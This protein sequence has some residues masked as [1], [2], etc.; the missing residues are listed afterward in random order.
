MLITAQSYNK[1]ETSIQ[2]QREESA[3][4]SNESRKM[5]WI[6][7]VMRERERESLLAQALNNFMQK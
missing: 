3:E 4:K 5:L 1:F 2:L 7:Q 6:L